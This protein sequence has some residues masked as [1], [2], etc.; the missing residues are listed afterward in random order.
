MTRGTTR[1]GVPITWLS[2]L[3]ALAGVPL[4]V[5][6]WLGW[7]LLEQD[8]ALETQR[9]R[10]R[11]DNSASVIARELD[12]TLTSWEELLA[13]AAR[14]DGAGLPAG[15]VFFVFDAG[16]VFQ[17]QGERLL[18]YPKV[19]E[20]S[21]PLP[22]AIV[23]A[24][25]LEF[26]RRDLVQAARAYRAIASSADPVVRAASLMRLARVLRADG[27]AADALGVYD[28]LAAL[29]DVHVSG[30]PAGLVGLR[31]R[32]AL[33]RAMGREPRPV[34]TAR[35]HDALW[36]GRFDIDKA[37]FDF[38]SESLA[39][40][41]EVPPGPGALLAEAAQ[42][43]WSEWQRPAGRAG[44]SAEAGAVVT[45]W[46]R[47]PTGTAALIA[48]VTALIAGPTAVAENLQVRLTLEDEAGNAAWGTRT[49]GP[50]GVRS[51]YREPGLPWTLHVADRD[52]GARQTTV[53]SRRNAVLLGF[54]L[55]FLVIATASYVAFRALQ[56]EFAVARLQSDFVAAV[57]HEF[58]SPLTAMC[59]L[60]EM[61]EGGHASSDRLAD[62]Y[63]AL[64]R[65]SRRLRNMVES[66][67][68]FSR[69]DAGQRAYQFEDTDAAEL[70]DRVVR[71][72]RDQSPATA[73]RIEWHVPSDGAD[74]PVWIRADREALALALRNLVDNAVKYSPASSPVR[75]SVTSRG[76]VV[77]IAVE[78]EGAGIS[79]I[80]RR[81]I[82]Q[83]FARGSAA[84]LLNVK[85]TG[86]GLTMAEQIVRAHGGRLE[87]ESELGR[88]TRFTTLLPVQS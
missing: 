73:D 75:V 58:R 55:V 62:Y 7:R 25:G 45:V 65:E 70:V 33:M 31:E 17:H 88:G 12:R 30:A 26:G 51:T 16:G 67:L 83:K 2:I 41:N 68:D 48:P 84:Q 46:R 3:A 1:L 56:R 39:Q 15:S 53:S 20:S 76:H 32:L 11:L 49:D 59:H 13:P 5:I 60:A 43:F 61:L 24:E 8:R 38:Y 52:P 29:G 64:G 22:P 72:C 82:F 23:E 19:R 77:G 21:A 79:K 42:A 50:A 9:V 85:G 81:Q 87:L 54:G 14:G 47:T 4:L 18:Y 80:E 74:R 6:G 40:T 66:L 27:A 28:Q 35:L 71:E 34:D 63:R 44:W 69:F 57:S 36:H 78:D 10:E 86:I 37:T